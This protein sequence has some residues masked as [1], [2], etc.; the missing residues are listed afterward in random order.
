ML[1]QVNISMQE[2]KL[3]PVLT[4]FTK[5][6]LK[7]FIG[8]TYAEAEP[9]VLWPLDAKKWL[10]R[11]E[12][13]AGRDWGQ[14]EKGMKRMRRVDSITDGGREFEQALGAGDG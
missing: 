13:D 7:E 1:K 2:M 3:D 5:I 10:I 14:E 6:N 11:K 12:P 9:P 4:A 8:R